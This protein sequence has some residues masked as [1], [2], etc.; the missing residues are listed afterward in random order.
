[1][2]LDYEPALISVVCRY[3]YTWIRSLQHPG[4]GVCKPEALTA[5][6]CVIGMEVMRNSRSGHPLVVEKTSFFTVQLEDHQVLARTPTRNGRD[7]VLGRNPFAEAGRTQLLT[8]L[9]L[10]LF[11]AFSPIAYMA[12][13]A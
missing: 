10:H 6:E 1:M 3:P 8:L 9:P 5:K 11:I 4:D 7:M 12:V 2:N 13:D